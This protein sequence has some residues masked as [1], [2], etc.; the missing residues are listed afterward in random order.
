MMMMMMMMTTTTTVAAG[1]TATTTTMIKV[2]NKLLEKKINMK[3]RSASFLIFVT[4]S[5]YGV[6]QLWHITSF[7]EFFIHI[8]F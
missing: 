3:K 8:K 7:D 4:I 2:K 1:T 6:I 5:E